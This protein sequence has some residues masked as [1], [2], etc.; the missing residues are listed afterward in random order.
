MQLDFLFEHA[1]G[2]GIYNPP[3]TLAGLPAN[4]G[5][6]RALS[7]FTTALLRPTEFQISVQSGANTEA[8]SAVIRMDR[9]LEPA[10]AAG[11]RVFDWPQGTGLRPPSGIF[12][13]RLQSHADPSDLDDRTF[14][15]LDFRLDPATTLA[16]FMLALR[17]TWPGVVDVP[18]TLSGNRDWRSTPKAAPS[19][20]F[21][22]DQETAAAVVAWDKLAGI[23]SGAM[24]LPSRT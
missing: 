18:R 20:E 17:S 6:Y 24:R 21:L 16:D 8:G 10:F 13:F 22:D 3:T 23:P 11:L 15:E 1:D 14:A 5:W 9:F 12:P 4:Q 19:L 7:D 2:I